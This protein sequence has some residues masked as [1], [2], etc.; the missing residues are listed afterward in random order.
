MEAP[1]TE[2]HVYA[3]HE[4]VSQVKDKSQAIG[5][6]LQ[7]LADQGI[8]LGKYVNDEIKTYDGDSDSFTVTHFRPHHERIEDLLARYYNIDLNKLER[9]KREMLAE[10]RKRNAA[11]KIDRELGL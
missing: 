6:F 1:R 8:Q 7:W 11:E 4:R 5:E 2:T 9:E 3:E 10:L